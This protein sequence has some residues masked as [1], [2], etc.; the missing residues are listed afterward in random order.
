MPLA[1]CCVA[2]RVARRFAGAYL[3]ESVVCACRDNAW[4]EGNPG[5]RALR[6]VVLLIRDR[7]AVCQQAGREDQAPSS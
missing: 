7:L 5:A 2:S 4:V 1:M 6:D 3:I